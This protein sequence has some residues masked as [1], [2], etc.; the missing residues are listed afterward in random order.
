MT[1][2]PFVT[3]PGGDVI[4]A[5]ASTTR[6]KLLRDAGVSFF[7]YPVI[8]DEEAARISSIADGIPVSEIAVILAEMKAAAAYQRLVIEQMV[9]P[10]YILGCDQILVCDENIFRKPEDIEEAKSQLFALSGKTHQLLTGIVLFQYGERIWHHLSVANMTMRH[11]NQDFIDGYLSRLGDAAF[12]SPASYQIESIGVHL[13]S[14]IKGCHYSI[15]GIPLL[16]LMAILR[17]HGLAPVE[18]KSQNKVDSGS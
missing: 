1:I 13:F 12:L 2:P 10:A 8:I 7:Q 18:S 14:E 9:T 6:A 16:E 5:S 3:L 17:E 4:L 15:A 11:F